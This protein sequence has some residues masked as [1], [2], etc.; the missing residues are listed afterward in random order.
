MPKY[1]DNAQNRRLKRVGKGYGKECSPCKVKKKAPPMKIKKPEHL[2]K[3]KGPSQVKVTHKPPSSTMKIKPKPS[4]P[5]KSKP[6]PKTAKA[7]AGDRIDLYD[8]S[9]SNDT[10]LKFKSAI[11]KDGVG[12]YFI[13]DEKV[14][15]NEIGARAE[16]TYYLLSPTYEENKRDATRQN[17]VPQV[18]V[19]SNKI[20][21]EELGYGLYFTEKRALRMYGSGGQL[22][23]RIE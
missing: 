20:F 23:W 3:K 19:W 5:K 4:V 8:T 12:E 6:K 1:I 2:L 9:L 16:R 22:H 10:L 18:A 14:K 7:R 11:D 17:D 13:V 15:G 21:H